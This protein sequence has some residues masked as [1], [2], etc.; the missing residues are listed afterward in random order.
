M[1]N[2]NFNTSSAY[3]AVRIDTSLET[4]PL[5]PVFRSLKDEVF[6]YEP[7]PRVSYNQVS[8]NLQQGYISEF[9]LKVLCL[10]ATFGSACVTTKALK[11]FLHMN[12]EELGSQDHRLIN[13]L[14]RL[15][16]NNLITCG[17]FKSPEKENPSLIKIILLT[18]YGSKLAKSMGVAHRFNHLEVLDAPTVKSRAQ[19]SMIAAT[20]MKNLT[21]RIERFEVR[22]IIVRND[23]ADAIVRPALKLRMFDEDVYFEVPR[24]GNADYLDNIT[25]KLHRYTLVFESIPSIV[26]NG[27]DEAMN[28]TIFK[29]LQEHLS[30]HNVDPTN[31]FFTDDLAQFGPG[32]NSCLYSFDQDGNKLRFEF[33]APTTAA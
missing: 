1:K 15:S 5:N 23:I 2:Y 18:G 3:K 20:F 10:I 26:I 4:T 6:F 33:A 16:Q 19:T 31:I 12:G 14:R 29:H 17:R 22:P 32:F 25:D 11:T 7:Q 9:D 27:E 28:R 13:S 30:E 21:D 8:Y 24:S